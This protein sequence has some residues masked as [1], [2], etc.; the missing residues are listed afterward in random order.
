MSTSPLSL[1]SL[2]LLT[3]LIGLPAGAFAADPVYPPGSRFGFEPAKEMVVSRR[4]TG[5]ERQSGGATV[6]VVELPAQAYKDLATNFTDENLKSQGL[7]VKTRETLKLADGREGC[8]SP[9]SSRSS[10]PRARRPCT[11]G[12]SS[13]PTRP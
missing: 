9:A 4:F 6:S 13:S 8:W 2:A 5:F 12:S 11:N 1:R 7:V 10:S 3:G